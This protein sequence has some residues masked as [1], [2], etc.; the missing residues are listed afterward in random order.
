MCEGSEDQIVE[1]RGKEGGE[2]R[3]E[4]KGGEGRRTGE[5]GGEGR[6]VQREEEEGEEGRN[7]YVFCFLYTIYFFLV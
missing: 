2:W 7:V 1:G 6:R 5:K 3:R 4:E